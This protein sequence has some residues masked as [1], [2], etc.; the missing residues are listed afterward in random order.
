M[1]GRTPPDPLGLLREAAAREPEPGRRQALEDA[2]DEIARELGTL[3]EANTRLVQIEHHYRELFESTYDG[4]FLSDPET[5]RIVEVNERACELVGYRR[6]EL[7]GMRAEDLHPYEVGKLREFFGE[8]CRHGRWSSHELTCR[9][10][11]GELVPTQLSSTAVVL[12]GRSCVL[13]L[14][15]D[16]RTHRLA[17][18]GQA[19][20][21]IGHDL[22]NILATV[23]LLS[24]SLAA[25]EDPKVQ[26]IT[27]RL[28]DSVDRAITMCVDTLA[29]GKVRQP[30]LRRTRVRLRQVVED[31]AA[32]AGMEAR[33]DIA[34]HNEVA[35][36]LRLGADPDHLFRVLLNL[37]RNACEAL[38]RGGSVRVS[39][40][41][42]DGATVILV[43]DDGPGL[44]EPVLA[45]LFQ[46]F[47][48][49]RPGG[50]G[51]GLAIARD[52]IE[53]H[54]GRI[55]LAHTGP[56]GT[57]FRIELPER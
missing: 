48:G 7:V 24:D 47:A 50:S 8:V 16:L 42:A 55:A 45:R 32:T 26:R 25:S 15:H 44:P 54:G 22:R 33:G 6:E 52:L 56:S 18:L 30:P 2:V 9:T 27:P 10:K 13:T 53:A 51:L 46:P 1:D 5:G 19:V 31:A 20:G 35:G 14:A 3:R 43:E 57:R 28:L 41:H 40:G 11:W 17:E 37:L 21:K 34:W 38:E 39:A 23:Q 4:I 29:P 49:T 12:Q 36:D